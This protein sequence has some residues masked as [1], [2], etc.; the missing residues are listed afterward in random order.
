[1]LHSSESP[2]VYVEKDSYLLTGETLCCD[3]S[4]A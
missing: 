4:R 3:M 2:H 1:M